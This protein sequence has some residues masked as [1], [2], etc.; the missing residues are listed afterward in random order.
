[1]II[2][3]SH[4]KAAQIPCT[5]T[6]S[7]LGFELESLNSHHFLGRSRWPCWLL[8][9][10]CHIPAPTHVLSSIAGIRQCQEAILYVCTQ[11]YYRPVAPGWA[12]Q[13][14]HHSI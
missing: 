13:I 5:G 2:Q 7:P 9:Q 10:K 6:F 3:F 14:E 11:M 12:G 8:Q 4:K 1:M